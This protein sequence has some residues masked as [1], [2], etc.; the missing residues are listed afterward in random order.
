LGV[1]KKIKQ[2]FK[3]LASALYLMRCNMTI[4]KELLEHV[5]SYLYETY[6]IFGKIINDE[7]IEK[8]RIFGIREN[9]DSLLIELDK[10]KD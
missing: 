9:I 10:I 7:D 5:K 8:L 2:G 6:S 1:R 4:N 3:S